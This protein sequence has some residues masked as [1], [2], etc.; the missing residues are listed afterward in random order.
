MPSCPRNTKLNFTSDL[1]RFSTLDSAV[2]PWVWFQSR[3][4]PP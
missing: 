4:W 1:G 3:D 2:Y